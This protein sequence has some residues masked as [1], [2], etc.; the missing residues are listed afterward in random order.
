MAV[1]EAPHQTDSTDSDSSFQPD[2]GEALIEEARQRARA[3]RS[4]TGESASSCRSPP[5]PRSPPP[6]PSWVP[7]HRRSTGPSSIPR[8]VPVLRSPTRRSRMPRSSRPGVRSRGVGPG[9]RRRTGHLVPRLRCVDGRRREPVRDR[10][11]RTHAGGPRARAVGS[12]RRGPVQPG[13]RAGRRLGGGRVATVRAAEYAV[14]HWE[15]GDPAAGGWPRRPSSL[16]FHPLLERSCAT[17]NGRSRGSPSLRP[18]P[19]RT[20][21]TGRVLRA[22]HRRG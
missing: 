7:A 9:L 21:G 11:A 4:A 16:S 2:P 15:Q 8:Q 10:R 1:T 5:S 18:R 13:A 3:R 20:P 14:C 17:G 12:P 19:P 22:H 6:W